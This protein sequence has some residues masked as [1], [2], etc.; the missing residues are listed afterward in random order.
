[1]EI[2]I[3]GFLILLNGLFALSEIALVSSKR[4]RL[5]QLRSEGRKGAVKAL[6]LHENSENFLSSVQVGI[7]LIGIITGAYGGVN[8]AEDVVPLI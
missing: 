7:T 8:L 6:K 2:V 4:S 3:I 5:E 1:M